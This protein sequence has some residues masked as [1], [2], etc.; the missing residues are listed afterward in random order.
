M[1]HFSF[2]KINFKNSILK[3]IYSP[4][5]SILL[6]KNKSVEINNKNINNRNKYGFKRSIHSIDDIFILT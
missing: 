3:F 6:Y 2:L 1:S 5:I 4:K